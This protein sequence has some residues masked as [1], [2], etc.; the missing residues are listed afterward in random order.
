[1][2]S[3]G[4]TPASCAKIPAETAGPFP[5]DGTIGPNALTTSG[6]VRNDITASFGASTTKAQGI[7]LTMK[8]KIVNTSAACAP[9][10]GAALYV[11]HCDRDGNYSLYTAAV[12][13]ENYLRGVA[14]ADANGEVT[15]TTIFPGC[16]PGRWPHVHFEVFAS[17]DKANSAANILATSQLA[18][19]KESCDAAYAQAGYQAS[20]AALSQLTLAGDGV[21]SDGATLQV[22][23]MSGDATAGFTSSLVV[24]VAG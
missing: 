4:P 9:L 21:F 1:M 6:I 14:V 23:T 17:V 11:W 24:G 13:N 19:T 2:T 5:G 15:F 22:A 10:S 18:F 12:A 20:A 3:G 16:Y 7:P 8:F